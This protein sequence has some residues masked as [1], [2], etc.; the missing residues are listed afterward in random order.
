LEVLAK[1]AVVVAVEQPDFVIWKAQAYPPMRNVS[2]RELL[3]LAEGS[4]ME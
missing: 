2:W 1:P 4:W 3:L